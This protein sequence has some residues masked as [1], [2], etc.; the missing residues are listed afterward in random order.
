MSQVWMFC[1]S[2]QNLRTDH[3][4][5]LSVFSLSPPKKKYFYEKNCRQI[6]KKTWAC[7]RKNWLSAAQKEGGFSATSFSAADRKQ[8]K[9]PT[10]PFSF[11]SI[12]PNNEISFS[13]K[14][15]ES[16]I[17]RIGNRQKRWEREARGIEKDAK[18]YLWR[19][20]K[21]TARQGWKH[22]ISLF[23][24]GFSSF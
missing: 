6:F 15:K 24:C 23:L 20:F 16:K 3:F 1:C 4:F 19:K 2:L 22:L 11:F 21:Q 18:N 17:P 12:K 10:N 14:G 8:Q 9:P 13:D 5:R 7:P